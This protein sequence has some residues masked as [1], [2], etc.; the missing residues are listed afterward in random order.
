MYPSF[1]GRRKSPCAT[2]SGAKGG[3]VLTLITLSLATAIFIAILSIRA[4]LLQTLD[5]ALY[6]FDYDVQV[7]FDRSYRA[8]PIQRTAL[9]IAGVD[10]VETWGFGTSRRIRP[11]DSESDSIITYAP[12][13]DSKML[14]PTLLEG[15]WL[16]PDDTNAIVLNTDVLR[17]EEDV[18]IG[19]MI[20]LNVGG[21]EA[22]WEIV[23]II[24]GLVDRIQRLS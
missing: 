3:L 4:S 20:T 10:E 11:D 2:P 5:D 24:R 16:Q 22:D 18:G 17:T 6:L 12:R 7:V 8:E 9:E 21:T 14:N 1:N 15:R 13:G 19:D 23:G